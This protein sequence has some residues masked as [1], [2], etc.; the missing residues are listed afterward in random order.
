M[1]SL[2]KRGN[3]YILTFVGD[4]EHRFNPTTFDAISDAL[5]E[6]E[7]SADAAA[8]V[9][10]NAGKYFSCGLDMKWV[11]ES[12]HDRF[13]IGMEKLENMFAA[14]MKLSIPTVAA[15][16]GHAE[17]SAFTL[18]LAHDYR[19]MS[20][21]GSSHLYMCELDHGFN[22]PKSMLTLIRSKLHPAAL[23]DVVLGGTKLNARMAFQKGIVDA[24]FDDS[25]GTLQAAVKEAEKLAVRG[26]NREI[27]RSFRL[28]AFPD[29]VEELDIHVPY[30]MLA[31]Y[32]F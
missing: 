3:V 31:S 19:F 14:F 11:G 5:K 17:A 8:L 10:T 23:R 18:A 7:E 15:I 30:R 24:A 27:Y 32:N 16:C 25:V 28:A 2:E 21:Q 4:R 12:P 26:W 22:I 1:C 13:D 20:T 29:V 6:V 9:T